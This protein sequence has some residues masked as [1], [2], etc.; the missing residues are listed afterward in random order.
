MFGSVS[1]GTPLNSF[2]FVTLNANMAANQAVSGNSPALTTANVSYQY[3][4]NL[5]INNVTYTGTFSD[6]NWLRMDITVMA[7]NGSGAAPNFATDDTPVVIYQKAHTG[8]NFDGTITPDLYFTGLYAVNNTIRATINSYSYLRISSIVASY[9]V[10][11]VEGTAPDEFTIAIPTTGAP[12]Y[13]NAIVGSSSTTTNDEGSGYSSFLPNGINPFQINVTIPDVMWFTGVANK[14]GIDIYKLRCPETITVRFYRMV[15]GG[16]HDLTTTANNSRFKIV[17]NRTPVSGLPFLYT[18]EL[19]TTSG[20][21][22]V[23]DMIGEYN[24]TGDY[25]ASLAAVAWSTDDYHQYD[26]EYVFPVK[27]LG[28]AT[29]PAVTRHSNWNTSR[30]NSDEPNSEI[31]KTGHDSW[32]LIFSPEQS[33]FRD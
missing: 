9:N 22:P 2:P 30:N 8:A 25:D 13:I 17:Y 1:Y 23:I 29:L 7:G 27:I 20:N 16:S 32:Q 15:T 33:I 3:S 26:L 21:L 28:N 14:Y 18:Y 19:D 31:F 11:A 12:S 5:L 10:L 4:E 24:I 6:Y